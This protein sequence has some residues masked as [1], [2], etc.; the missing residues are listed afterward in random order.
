MHVLATLPQALATKK[1]LY[2]IK[3]QS[4]GAPDGSHATDV[5]T[6][7]RAVSQQYRR[8]DSLYILSCIPQVVLAI[9]CSTVYSFH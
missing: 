8:L 6:F 2:Q 5:S 3:I 7:T 1:S 9:I 4:E